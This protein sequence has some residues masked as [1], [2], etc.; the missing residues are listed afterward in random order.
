MRSTGRFCAKCNKTVEYTEEPMED[1]H[2]KGWNQY[3]IHC[4]T[5]VGMRY[6]HKERRG[7]YSSYRSDFRRW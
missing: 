7:A 3:C 6:E 2:G 4:G 1:R 5:I